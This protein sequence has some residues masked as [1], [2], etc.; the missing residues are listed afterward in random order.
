MLRWWI[1]IESCNFFPIKFSKMGGGAE[2]L[3]KAS[4]KCSPTVTK[5]EQWKT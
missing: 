5:Q 3:I 1:T 2:K 4:Q